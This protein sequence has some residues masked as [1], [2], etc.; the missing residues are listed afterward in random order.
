MSPWLQP[1]KLQMCRLMLCLRAF[2][3]NSLPSTVE[4]SSWTKSQKNTVEMAKVCMAGE[5]GQGPAFAAHFFFVLEESL[6]PLL[7]LL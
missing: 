2:T 7:L 5:P 1:L 6:Y 3:G 4:I